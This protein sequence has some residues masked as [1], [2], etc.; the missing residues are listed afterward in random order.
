M[1]KSKLVLNYRAKFPVVLIVFLVATLAMTNGKMTDKISRKKAADHAVPL[2]QAPAI[3]DKLY[4]LCL[5]NW[6]SPA[7]HN[8]LEQLLG[9][10]DNKHE[11]LF[12]QFYLD[13]APQQHVLTLA[14][15]VGKNRRSDYDHTPQILQ[16][17][18]T[19][20]PMEL[21]RGWYLSDQEIS[22][23]K[24]AGKRAI[25][26][27]RSIINDDDY[28]YIIFHPTMGEENHI[29]FKLYYSNEANKLIDA[30]GSLNVITNPSPPKDAY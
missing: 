28:K 30:S 7:G 21:A 11:K 24:E 27:L 1:G 23:K 26:V 18:S 20:N 10:D 4:D 15:Y 25:E 14:A 2:G 12:L 22:R 17:Y 6:K 8:Q 5:E 19:E 29:V 9:V 13:T 16:V 3:S